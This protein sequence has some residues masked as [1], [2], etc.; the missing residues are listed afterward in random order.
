MPSGIFTAVSFNTVRM[1]MAM[2]GKGDATED[3]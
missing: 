3:V 1:P 2:F